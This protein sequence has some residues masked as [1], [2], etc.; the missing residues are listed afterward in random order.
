MCRGTRQT[1]SVGISQPQTPALL[2]LRNLAVDEVLILGP[3]CLSYS[4]GVWYCVGWSGV[5]MP[6]DRW[7][8]S[9]D[10]LVVIAGSPPPGSNTAEAWDLLSLKS[11]DSGH[12]PLKER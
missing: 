1:P 11:K 10:V 8:A 4:H 7:Q 5:E 6:D 3:D 9:L 2:R 12:S